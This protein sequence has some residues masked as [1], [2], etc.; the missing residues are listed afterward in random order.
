M[1]LNKK[2][3]VG[4]FYTGEVHF[5]CLSQF[6]YTG[7][8]ENKVFT[9]LPDTKTMFPKGAGGFAHLRLPGSTVITIPGC[10]GRERGMSGV[11]WTSIPR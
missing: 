8:G 1:M 3:R 4:P 5:L 9:F 10:R 6:N 2:L 11:S 7:S